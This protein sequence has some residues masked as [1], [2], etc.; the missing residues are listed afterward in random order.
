MLDNDLVQPALNGGLVLLVLLF[1][2]TIMQ[3][4]FSGG[5]LAQGIVSDS[6]RRA[7]AIVGSG[8]MVWDWDIPRD[9]IHTSGE[10]EKLLGLKKGALDGHAREWLE[11]LHPQDRDRFSST[12]YAVVEQRRGRVNQNFRLRAAD[13]HY[14]WFNLRARPVVGTDG[15]VVRCVGTLLDVTHQRNTEERMLHDA[16]HDNLT[17]LANREL[18]QDR[19]SSAMIRTRMEATA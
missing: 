10:A 12:L 17:G 4:A 5:I 15:E 13:G 19:L 16:V 7:L 11:V 2:F 8:D 1:S 3:H 6:E 18:L 9:H 14:R